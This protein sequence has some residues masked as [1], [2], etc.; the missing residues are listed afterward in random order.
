MAVVL[1]MLL[2]ITMISISGL[3]GVALQAD[4][5]SGMQETFNMRQAASNRI[6]S[7][8]TALMRD[9]YGSD[10]VVVDNQIRSHSI[11]PGT[12]RCMVAEGTSIGDA[13]QGLC[14]VVIGEAWYDNNTDN[15]VD[16]DAI[17]RRYTQGYMRI[18]A[19]GNSQ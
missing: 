14:G 1:V 9:R 2:L 18:R 7:R 17:V 5:T 19:L 10:A 3:R 12:V 8:V 4:L 6:E 11:L 16:D 15:T 13:L